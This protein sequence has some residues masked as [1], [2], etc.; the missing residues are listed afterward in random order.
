LKRLRD[1]ENI[2]LVLLRDGKIKTTFAPGLSLTSNVVNVRTFNS[3]RNRGA[4][5]QFKGTMFDGW[6]TI[7]PAGRAL[8]QEGETAGE[9]GE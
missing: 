7:T 1:G 2:Y 8:L 9:G 6:Y 3:L 4:V 5:S